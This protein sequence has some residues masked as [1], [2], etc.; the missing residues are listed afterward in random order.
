MLLQEKYKLHRAYQTDPS[1]TSKKVAFA[2]VQGIVQAKLRKMQY[3]WLSKK[4]Q[5]IQSYADRH[6]SKRIIDAL[7]ALYGPTLIT[8]KNRILEGGLSILNPCQTDNL[9]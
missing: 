1:S 5:E 8:E 7:K 2:N 3:S 6:D 9:L 4:S